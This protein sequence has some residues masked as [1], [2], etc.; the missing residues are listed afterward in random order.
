MGVGSLLR[1]VGREGDLEDI[2]QLRIVEKTKNR[3][4]KVLCYAVIVVPL[5]GS[6]SL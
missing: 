4:T 5:F 1:V 6:P 3:T 2:L